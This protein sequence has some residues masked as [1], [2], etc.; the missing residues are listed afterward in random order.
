[1]RAAAFA[2]ALVAGTCTAAEPWSATDT[3]LEVAALT[4]LTIDFHQTLQIHQQYAAG[5]ERGESNFLLGTHPSESKIRNYFVA[6]S[7]IQFAVAH[8]LSGGARTCFLSGVLGLEL[9]VT[10]RNKEIG[11][12][13]RF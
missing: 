3:A 10:Q 12:S 2:L 4:S 5:R 9:V 13:Y 1:M 11:L 8:S 7:L 6:S